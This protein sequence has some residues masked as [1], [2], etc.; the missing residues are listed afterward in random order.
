MAHHHHHAVTDY[1]RAFAIGVSL[2]MGFVVLE[3]SYGLWADSLALIADAGHNLSDVVGLLLA[4]GA[5][6]LAQAPATE[7]RTYGWRKLP[8]V[9]SL[10]SSLL[11]VAT[12]AVIGWEALQ[13]F[14]EPTDVLSTTMMVV[15]AVG[16]VTNT[17]T[18]L[19]F[20]HGQH[21]DLNLRGAFL[22]MAADAGVSLGVVLGGALVWW[23]Q[24]Q[25]VD[26]LLSLLIVAVILGSTWG[27]L[28]D[29]LDY[30]LDAV[31]RGINLSRIRQDLLAMETV[32]RLHDL[33]VWPLSTQ[34]VALTVHLV[35]RQHTL[36]N[37][38][39]HRIQAYLLEHYGIEHATIQVETNHEDIRCHLE[40]TSCG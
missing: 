19:M 31:P 4:W 9:A 23:L 7:K 15:A 22:H 33:H 12:S 39:L 40:P 37:A 21:H 13:R 6:S 30:A 2:N 29:S 32:E 3:L 5:H 10:L 17:L 8:V 38:F 14:F 36:D 25:W 16:I 27:L 20:A 35:V 1:N 24:W 28:Q 34:Q 18:A 26:P 11:L